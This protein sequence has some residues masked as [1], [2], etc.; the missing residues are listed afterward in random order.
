M[1]KQNNKTMI[2]R[3]IKQTLE[4]LSLIPYKT[5]KLDTGLIV[6]HYK[7]GKLIADKR[8]T[9]YKRNR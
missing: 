6:E 2:V 5:V 9:P 8:E 7:N 4:N 3:F 1:Y